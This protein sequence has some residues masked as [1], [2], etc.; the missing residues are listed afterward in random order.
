MVKAIQS[1]EKKIDELTQKLIDYMPQ[2]MLQP[3]ASPQA[4]VYT[5][6]QPA[7]LFHSVPPAPLHQVNESPMGQSTPIPIAPLSTKHNEMSATEI[8]KEKPKTIAETLQ[9]YASLRTESKI[10][11]L[12]FFIAQIFIVCRVSRVE[13]GMCKKPF[14]LCRNAHTLNLESIAWTKSLNILY[15]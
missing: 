15:I 12:A 7:T 8:P 9:K 3:L 2:P 1:M 13:R 6:M 11:V 4:Q 14:N 10:G 5:P